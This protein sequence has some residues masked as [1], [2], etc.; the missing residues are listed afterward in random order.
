MK[1]MI[2]NNVIFVFVIN[3]FIFMCIN[4]ILKFQIIFKFFYYFYYKNISINYFLIFLLLLDF[5]LKYFLVTN[6]IYFVN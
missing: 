2:N 4:L 6:F 3:Q 1:N 5:Q